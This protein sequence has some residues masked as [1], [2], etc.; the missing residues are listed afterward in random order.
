MRNIILPIIY[1][2]LISSYTWWSMLTWISNWTLCRNC[3]LCGPGMEQIIP[4]T[5]LFE[6]TH[7]PVVGALPWW[8]ANYRWERVMKRKE[9][10]NMEKEGEKMDRERIQG[11]G[12]P[13]RRCWSQ[14][15]WLEGLTITK[16][17]QNRKRQWG[18]SEDEIKNKYIIKITMV[19][20]WPHVYQGHLSWP[21]I[22]HVSAGV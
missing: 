7:Y 11:S 9:K 6:I 3:A 19:I 1:A 8:G 17:K 15:T 4:R 5:P 20:T 22:Y 21:H 10:K 2:L 16:T 14:I 18:Q 13:E 12:L